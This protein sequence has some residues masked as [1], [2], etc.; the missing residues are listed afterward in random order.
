MIFDKPPKILAHKSVITNF[1]F[2]T[3]EYILNKGTN[4][5]N[6][7]NRYCPHRMY[8]LS[9]PGNYVEN[10][11]CKFHGFEWDKNGV[12]LNNDKNIGCG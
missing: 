6:L 4:Q 9:K 2:V 8:P 3:P 5:V 7:F 11:V 12:P 1:N 10:I